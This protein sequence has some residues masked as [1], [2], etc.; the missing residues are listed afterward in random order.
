MFFPLLFDSFSKA[1]PKGECASL[2]CSI[3]LLWSDISSPVRYSFLSIYL[4]GIADIFAAC[5]FISYCSSSSLILSLVAMISFYILSTRFFLKG[6]G[7]SDGRVV[8]ITKGEYG[9]VNMVTLFIKIHKVLKVNIWWMIKW[10]LLKFP[11][12]WNFHNKIEC[13]I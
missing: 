13:W 11:F 8:S 12:V 9:F 5:L 7:L 4:D 1:F 3:I 2:T 10:N 6:K